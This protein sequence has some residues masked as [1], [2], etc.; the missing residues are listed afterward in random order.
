MPFALAPLTES[1]LNAAVELDRQVLGG[2]W[3][4]QS[5]REE[6]NRSSSDLVGL[7]STASEA[8][9]KVSLLAMGCAWTVLDEAH[10]VL[11]AVHPQH[12]RCGLG[13]GILLELL[14]AARRRGMKYATLEVRASNKAAIAL[15]TKLGFTTAGTRRNYYG[16]TGEDALVMW[17]SDLQTAEFTDQMVIHWETVRQRW[18]QCNRQ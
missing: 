2:F 9:G 1:C 10:I 3:S 17:R 18:Q 16:D 6:L 7:R 8:E 13:Y 14:E 4:A 15:Y 11:M 5:Y 12:R